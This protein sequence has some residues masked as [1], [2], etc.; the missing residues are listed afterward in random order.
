MNK[1]Y[2][3]KPTEVVRRWYIVDASQIPFGRLSTQ[4]A[5]LLTGKHKPMYTPHIDCGD[6]VI[7]INASSLVSTGNKLIDKK[8][9]RHTGFPGGIKDTTLGKKV[10]KNPESVI[11]AAV[12]GMIHANKLRPGRLARLKVYKG[13]EHNHAAQ[14]PVEFKLVNKASKS[15]SNEVKN[16]EKTT[17]TIAKDKK[18]Q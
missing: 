14:K 9:Y 12:K 11:E 8:Y 7:V 15:K 3:A 13:S 17:S 2:S 10:E 16:Q 18:E 5:T 4:V 1:T 6:Y